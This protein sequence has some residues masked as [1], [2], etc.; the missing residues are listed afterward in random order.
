[1]PAI[2]PARR[3]AGVRPAYK[4]VD[5]CAAEFRSSTPYMYSSYE[6]PAFGAQAPECEAE[7]SSR[8]K[9]IILGGGPNRIG[10]GIEFDYCC[11]HASF[12]LAEEEIEQLTAQQAQLLEEM[13]N[14]LVMADD[15]HIDAVIIA[16][17]DHWHAP[18]S[19]M[20]CQAGKDVYVEKPAHHSCWEGQ[21]MVQA[22]RRYE[23]VVQVGTQN[24][25]A[26]YNMA[27]RDYVP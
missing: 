4:R 15:M 24:R 21:Q 22:A 7:V 13:Q 17:P 9:V 1:M 3:A 27:A 12:A 23:R 8:K 26:P 20:A 14:T 18:M 11:C 19:I 16:T 10:Q 6:A 2:C 5:T 25:S